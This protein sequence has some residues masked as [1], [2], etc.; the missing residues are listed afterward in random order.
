MNRFVDSS[1]VARHRKPRAVR[2]YR[3]ISRAKFAL[4]QSVCEPS[5]VC[6]RTDFGGVWKVGAYREHTRRIHLIDERAETRF[7][8]IEIAINVGVIELDRRDYRAARAV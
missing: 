6:T 2:A 5:R 7:Y 8:V 3:D 1:A 4:A